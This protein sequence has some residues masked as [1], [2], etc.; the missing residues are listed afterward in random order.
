VLYQTVTTSCWYQVRLVEADG[1]V[2]DQEQD[3]W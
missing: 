3:Q 1:W 2:E